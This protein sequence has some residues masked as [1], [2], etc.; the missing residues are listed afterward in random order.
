MDAPPDLNRSRTAPNKSAEKQMARRELMMLYRRVNKEMVS[1]DHM[2]TSQRFIDAPDGTQPYPVQLPEETEYYQRALENLNACI[3]MTMNV[4]ENVLSMAKSGSSATAASE[5]LT[6]FQ[7]GANAVRTELV[8]YLTTCF[9]HIYS[10]YVVGKTYTKFKKH[11]GKHIENLRFLLS[12]VQ[13][14]V[15]AYSPLLPKTHD[16]FLWGMG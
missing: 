2:K 3:L 7:A 12:V 1:S 5:Q 4:P 6:A 16:F 11:M 8:R 9:S 14:I 13:R 10:E 15:Y